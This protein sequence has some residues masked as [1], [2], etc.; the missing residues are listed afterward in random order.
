MQIPV[1]TPPAHFIHA[2]STRNN[3]NI[4]Y[5]MSSLADGKLFEI[6]VNRYKEFMRNQ[7]MQLLHAT[8]Q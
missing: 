8:S 7:P 6:N 3:F 4:H 1:Y 5:I 2:S